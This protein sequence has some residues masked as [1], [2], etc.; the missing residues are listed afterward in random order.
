MLI[1]ILLAAALSPAA[2]KLKHETEERARA[3]AAD[4]LKTLCPEQCVLLSI[5]AR[6]EEE[7]V[8]TAPAPG[9][10]TSVTRTVPVLRG[11]VASLVIDQRLPAAFRSR[12]KALVGQRLGGAGMPATVAVEQVPFPP[13]SPAYLEPQQ[14]PAAPQLVA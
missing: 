2:Q 8:G 6:I 12:L 7:D 9:F 13:R 14:P 1:A 10:E 11:V 3:D 5:E 4:L